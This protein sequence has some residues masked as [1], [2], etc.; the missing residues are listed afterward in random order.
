[1]EVE[2]AVLDA[3]VDAAQREI[4]ELQDTRDAIEDSNGQ[5]I[6]GLQNA[7]D[8]EREMYEDQQSSNDLDSKMRQLAILQATGG[9]ASEISSLQKEIDAAQRDIYLDKQQEQIDAIQDA[10]DRQIEKLDEQI[11]L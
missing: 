7:L 9:S 8:K 6:E 5:F 4:D 1:M 3:I 11:K 10:S 2:N